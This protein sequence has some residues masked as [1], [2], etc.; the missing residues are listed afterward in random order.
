MAF[1][2]R[3]RTL[4]ITGLT[5]DELDRLLARATVEGSVSSGGRA[6]NPDY[7]LHFFEY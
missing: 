4:T 5:R 6:P 7:F 1:V 3:P 2:P